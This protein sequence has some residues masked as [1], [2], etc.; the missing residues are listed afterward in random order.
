MTAALRILGSVWLA[1]ILVVMM[2][3]F[4]IT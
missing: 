1:L 2:V 4:G 3:P